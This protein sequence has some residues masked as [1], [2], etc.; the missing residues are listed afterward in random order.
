MSLHMAMP[1]VG[2]QSMK[3]IIAFD[4]GTMFS[5]VSYAFLIPGLSPTIRAVTQFPG[6]QKTGG[7]SKIPSVVC[8]D[9]GGNVVAVGS[10]ADIDMNPELLEVQGLVRVEWY[11]DKTT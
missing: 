8:Y 4:V 9:Q 11:V 6:Q 2:N 3:L 7:D 1:Y 5:R 10:Q